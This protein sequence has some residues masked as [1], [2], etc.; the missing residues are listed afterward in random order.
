M[1]CSR[2]K[3]TS[4]WVVCILYTCW[5][6]QLPDCVLSYVRLF[7]TLWTLDHQAP[8]SIEL[9]SK[10]TGVGCHFFLQGIFPTQGSNPHLLCLLH[11][12][13]DSF[14]TESPGEPKLPDYDLFK[15]RI[16]H[17]AI[18]AWEGQVLTDILWSLTYFFS[19]IWKELSILNKMGRKK[20]QVNNSPIQDGGSVGGNHG[21]NFLL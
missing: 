5:L 12:Q 18:L 4:K 21:G 14:T 9:S 1:F 20:F 19:R 8:L 3:E 2:L 11:W 15:E 16:C 10:S 6:G 17:F 7:V 13:A